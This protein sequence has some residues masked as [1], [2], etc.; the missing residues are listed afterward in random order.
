MSELNASNLRKEHGNEGPDL[1]GVTELTSPYFM[2]PPSGTT[3]ERPQ[4]AQ[5]GTLR[6]NTDIGSLEYFKG[7]DLGWVQIQRTTPNLDGG[8][9]GLF[10]GGSNEPDPSSTY[11][12]IEYITIPTLGN[13]TDFGNLSSARQEGGAFASSTRGVYFGGDPGI[14][15]IE[16]VTIS[17]TGNATNFGDTTG[18]QSKAGSGAA[19]QTRGLMALGWANPTSVD[20]IEYVTTASTGNG[21]D[22]GNLTATLYEGSG[23]SSSTR[24]IFTI[25]YDIPSTT[26]KNTIDYVT[27]QTTGNA[28]DF[29]DLT[30]ARGYVAGAFSGA[31]RGIICGGYAG[32]P[33]STRVNTIDYVTIATLGNAID[34]GDMTTLNGYAAGCSSKLRGVCASGYGT[35]APTNTIVNSMEYIELATKG[36][37]VDFGDVTQKRRHIKGCSNAHGG[38]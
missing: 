30:V 34:F 11:D 7:D 22:F 18:D 9:R 19:D 16:Y 14:N 20:I 29:G 27:I 24:G 15:T 35:V 17:S 37:S 28:S 6:F 12:I 4:N 1:V 33:L 23:F 10:M 31:T 5:P 38:L 32:S 25:G 36:N 26:Y 13:G 2:V 21:V 3:A 8:A